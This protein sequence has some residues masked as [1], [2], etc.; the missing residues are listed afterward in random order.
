MK[1]KLFHG[2]YLPGKARRT[3]SVPDPLIEGR[4][5]TSTTNYDVVDGLVL[6]NVSGFGE[7]SK[8]TGFGRTGEDFITCTG[9]YTDGK[10]T[11]I[12]VIGA[13]VA[14]FA[15]AIL[16]DA[17][18]KSNVDKTNP[19]NPLIVEHEVVAIGTPMPGGAILVNELYLMADGKK[20][21]IIAAEAQAVNA[22]T[23]AAYF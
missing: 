1:T 16:H 7:E 6:G 22:T 19:D 9:K 4:M 23:E 20:V 13:N 14:P 15:K 10:L 3:V 21:A 11:R 12:T 5:L 2:H 18:G 8:G 17:E